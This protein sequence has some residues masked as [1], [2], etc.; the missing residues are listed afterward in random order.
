MLHTLPQCMH[1]FVS[2]LFTP[3]FYWRGNAMCFERASAEQVHQT[4]ARVPTCWE[5]QLLHALIAASSDASHH[6]AAKL[7]AGILFR[8]QLTVH[9]PLCAFTS[10]LGR[11]RS[12][13]RSKGAS[14][15]GNRTFACKLQLIRSTPPYS[16]KA[17][18]RNLVLHMS[19]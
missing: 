12:P 8:T 9:A 3:T 18:N 1:P 4:T 15:W 2:L 14:L 7:P 5:T 16:S 6:A 13:D 10:R 17:I 19:H 11:A